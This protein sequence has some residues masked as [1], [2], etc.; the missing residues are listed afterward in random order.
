LIG[1][2]LKDAQPRLQQMKAAA[3]AG[4]L[5]RLAAATHTFKGSASNLGARRLAALCAALEKQSKAG[6]AGQSSQTLAEVIAEF[7]TVRE[8]LNA[9]LEN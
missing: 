8:L 7:T 1:L 6:D 5:P 3:S 4:D 9:E 2:F